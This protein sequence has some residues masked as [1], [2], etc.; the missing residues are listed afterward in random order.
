[1]MLLPALAAG[2]RIAFL[3]V[4]A[5]VIGAAL[6]LAIATV[7]GA[8]WDPVAR[9]IPLLPMAL[10]GAAALGLTQL[11]TP[12]PPHLALWMNP[13]GV[14]VRCVLAVGLL[15][16]TMQRLQSRSSATGAAILLAGYAA[17]VTPVAFDWLLGGEPGQ[18]VSAAGMMLAVRQVA[19]A[20]ALLLVLGWGEVAFRRDMA[21][22]MVAAALGLGYLHFMD[23]L[24]VWFGNLPDRV[25]FYVDRSHGVAALLPPLALL[26]GWAVPIG[27][28]AAGRAHRWAGGSTLAALFVIDCWWVGGGIVAALL[29]AILIAGVALVARM[30]LRREAL[31]G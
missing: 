2:W 8:R 28:L 13:I 14:A 24:I 22:L 17:L 10:V 27:L 6:L 19:G 31:H 18:P 20:T 11:A 3:L 25:G 7:T 16:W 30:L 4:Q 1:M 26:L 5:P 21:R 12:A 29:A 15:L 23:Y 9:L